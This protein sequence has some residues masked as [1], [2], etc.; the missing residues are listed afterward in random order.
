MIEKLNA[1]YERLQGLSITP[2]V[3]NMERLLQSLYDIRD[4]YNELQKAGEVDG[5]STSDSE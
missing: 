1:A 4:V 2:T 3:S 5:R